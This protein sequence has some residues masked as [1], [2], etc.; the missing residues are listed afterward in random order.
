MDSATKAVVLNLPRKTF[1]G[2]ISFV[3]LACACLM[4]TPAY[5]FPAPQA[6][7]SVHITLMGTTDL[8]AHIEPV[9]YY[10]NKPLAL[11]FAKI[12]TLIRGIRKEQPNSL[13]LDA[14]DMIQGTPLGYYFAT[15]ERA[16]PN[17]MMLVMNAL[18]YDAAAVGNHEFNFGLDYLWKTKREAHFPILAA[19]IKQTYTSGVE[20]FD[21]YIIKNVAGVRV[22]LVGFVTQSIPHWEVSAHYKGY[23]FESIVTAARRVIPEVRKKAD[24]VVVIAHSGM[25][26][27]PEEKTPSLFIEIPGENQVLELANQVPGIDVIL[28]GHTHSQVAERI[29]NGV[30][31]TQP[32]NWG[33][34]LARIDLDVAR[35]A[36]G[37]WQ[38]ASKHSTVIPVTAD[39]PVDSEVTQLA[40]PY[41]QAT[42][43]Y[44][45]TPVATSAK[46]MSGATAR[47]EDEPLTDLIHTV[48]LEAGHAEISMATMLFTGVKIPL[49]KVTTRQIAALY[50][51]ENTLYTVEMTGAQFRDAL[52]HA[53]GVYQSWPLPAGEQLHLPTY[54]VDSAA[55]VNYTIDLR[56]PVGHRIVNLTYKGK[57]LDDSQKFRVAINNYRY[58]GGGGYDVYKGLPV[59]YRSTQEVR[60]LIAEYLHR[61][62]VVPT[63]ANNNWHIEP[64][65]AVDALRKLALDQENRPATASLGFSLRTLTRAPTTPSPGAGVPDGFRS[66]LPRSVSTT[67]STAGN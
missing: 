29:V 21:P 37:H 62:G 25:G 31:L 42:Q 12:A 13:L 4:I 60:E 65:E 15:E 6:A 1:K 51:Y 32:K 58:G 52:E 30:L 64:K 54:N 33:G 23:E 24:V 9:D 50:I 67:Y 34:S 63:T 8:H 3:L 45:D 26:P 36:D 56:Q 66:F 53:A 35:S 27:D 17:P 28:F 57:P 48:Q 46:E 7:E 18:G 5:S 19:N 14:G 47:I 41:E 22:A 59:T 10:A 20:H 2:R 43:A 61:T 16:K 38:I 44:L 40:A 11:G 49:G 39:T 55:G